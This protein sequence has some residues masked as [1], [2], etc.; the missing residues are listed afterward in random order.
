MFDIY[1][2]QR[3]KDLLARQE[4]Y[5]KKKDGDGRNWPFHFEM[6]KL[7]SNVYRGVKLLPNLKEI[8]AEEF[9]DHPSVSGSYGSQM[10]GSSSC[11]HMPGFVYTRYAK[12]LMTCVQNNAGEG[13]AFVAVP[14]LDTKEQWDKSQHYP[15]EK[16]LRYWSF[17]ICDHQ[18]REVLTLGRSPGSCVHTYRCQSCDWTY[19]IDSSG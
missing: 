6:D 19:E 4:E 8:T 15:V 1:E 10:L 16:K 17:H 3:A 7:K 5:R 14:K 2:I 11:E 9:A 13:V 12:V 18:Y